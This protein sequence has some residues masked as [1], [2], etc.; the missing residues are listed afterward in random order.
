MVHDVRQALRQLSRTP[1]LSA[2]IVVSLAVGIGANAAVYSAVEA[3]LLRAPVGVGAA[4]LVDIY[5]S[6]TN[7]ARSA[8]FRFGISMPSG[9]AA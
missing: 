5:T 4:R 9:M 1:W 3:L 7:G 2:V 8:A 6:Q